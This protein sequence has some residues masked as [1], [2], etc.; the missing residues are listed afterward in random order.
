MTSAVLIAGGLCGAVLAVA[1]VLVL[2]WKINAWL[3]RAVD[4]LAELGPDRDGHTLRDR[5][6]DVQER[7][8]GVK[9]RLDSHLADHHHGRLWRRE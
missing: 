1:A 9:G 6:I 3:V 8:G 5:V 4:L 7:L 2:G